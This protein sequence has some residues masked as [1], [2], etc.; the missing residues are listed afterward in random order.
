MSSSSDEVSTANRKRKRKEKIESK[1]KQKIGTSEPTTSVE[2]DDNADSMNESEEE[3]QNIDEDEISP[4]GN[5]GESENQSQDHETEPVVNTTPNISSHFISEIVET[6]QIIVIDS[7]ERIEITPTNLNTNSSSNIFATAMNLPEENEPFSCRIC[8][9][10]A[11]HP[12]K[13]K[14]L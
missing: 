5:Q 4:T 6:P 8:F 11:E 10:K 14:C 13:S 9:D 3:P 7:P 12:G 2:S 1:K